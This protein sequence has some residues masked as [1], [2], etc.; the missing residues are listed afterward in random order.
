MAGDTNCCCDLTPHPEDKLTWTGNLA[1]DGWRYQLIRESCHVEYIEV[2]MHTAAGTDS[3]TARFFTTEEPTPT[4]PDTEGEND[5]NIWQVSLGNNEG[6]TVYT[7]DQFAGMYFRNGVFVEL[8]SLDSTAEVIINVIYYLRDDYT[9]AIPE[10][11]YERR[12]RLWNCYNETPYGDNF[13]GGYTGDDYPDTDTSN[14]TPG[15]MPGS[16]IGDS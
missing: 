16:S 5:V 13:P 3:V 1:A 2:F 15:D 14:T 7:P 10:R 9:P 11:P 4:P 8:V 12:I 6:G